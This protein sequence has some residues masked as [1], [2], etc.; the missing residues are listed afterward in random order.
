MKFDATKPVQTRD[1]RKARI[2][3]ADAKNYD[4]IVA[5][6]DDGD[7]KEYVVHR[8]G[9]GRYCEGRNDVADLINIPEPVEGWVNVYPGEFLF[10]RTKELADAGCRTERIACIPIKFVRGEGL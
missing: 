5:L 8:R 3:C 4:P 6:V 2:V 1:G 9:D 7:G 10:H